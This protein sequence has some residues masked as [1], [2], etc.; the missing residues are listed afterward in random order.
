MDKTLNQFL[1]SYLVYRDD[2]KKHNF[3]SQL[4]EQTGLFCVPSD[5]IDKFWDLYCGQLKKMGSSFISGVCERPREYMPVLGD[6]DIHFFEDD[7]KD[8]DLTKHFYTEKHVKHIVTIYQDVLKYLVSEYSP[9]NLYCFVLEKKKPHR[10]EAKVKNGFHIH[11]PFLFM[12]KLDIAANLYDRI[13]KRVEEEQVFKDIG[14]EHSGDLIDKGM[15]KKYWLL[16][17]SRKSINKEPYLLT[18]I[19]DYKGR[20]V[21]LE[22]IKDD[23]KIFNNDEELI[24]LTDENINSLIPRI[25]SINSYRRSIFDVK[26]EIEFEYKRKLPKAENIN[27]V[28]GDV[29]VSALLQ[30]AKVLIDIISPTRADNYDTWMEVGWVLYNIGE[31]CQESLDL[32][33]NFSGRTTRDNF[34]EETCI[35]NWKKMTKGNWSIGSLKHWAHQDDCKKYEEL[36]K[37]KNKKLMRESL[38]GSDADLAQQLYEKLGHMFVCASIAGNLWYEFREHRWRKTDGGHALRAHIAKELVPRYIELGKEYTDKYATSDVAESKQIS[39]TQT[40]ISRLITNLKKHSSRE[41][42]MKECRHLFYREDFLSK[43]NAD[44]YLMGF[45]N[46]VLDLKNLEFRDGKPEDYVSMTTGY[47]FRSFSD[48]DPEI[49]D[50]KLFLMKIFPDPELRTYFVEYGAKLLRGGNFDKNFLVMTGEKGDNGKSVTIDLVIK[51]LGKYGVTIP[52]S[53]ITQKRGA[54]SQ[55]APELV[56]CIGTR[57]VVAQEPEKS[58]KVNGG[59]LKELTG[60][61]NMFVRGLY[62]EGDDTKFQ[63]KM[64]LVTNG[65]PRLPSD[66]Q[67]IWNRVRVLPF[68]STFPKDSG[69]VPDDFNEQLRQKIFERDD[70]ISEKFDN[71]KQALMYVLFQTYVHLQK[72]KK[73]VYEPKK[74]TEAT[75]LYRQNNDI[76]LQYVNETIVEDNNP[77]LAGITVTEIYASFKDWFRET[78]SN[79]HLPTKN[80]LRDDLYRR[81]GVP[82][83]NNKWT[84]YRFRNPQDDIAEGKALDLNSDDFTDGETDV[85]ADE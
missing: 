71:M 23:I 59:L 83:T 68:E 64:C 16:Y 18:K 51:M 79:M 85:D 42:I 61:D 1:K 6:I 50:I 76:Y 65:L 54:S 14:I 40:K 28:T 41:N 63:F 80:D 48:G 74:V 33:I 30:E 43:L 46:G 67:A 22:Q 35:K 53:L 24:D 3:S 32:W 11:F 66:D 37:D 31:G 12:N 69:L 78:F 29:P 13:K 49:Y 73:K 44:V 39:D 62:Q 17:G 72:R 36:I 77:H 82:S 19:F 60:S 57:F 47:D 45:N 84:K 56:R 4:K 34:S 9:E 26:K 58:D 25:L 15:E 70:N 2:E 20:I 5:N 81:W 7:H 38:E 75:R 55:A 52:T 27:R 21:T 10:E 8:R